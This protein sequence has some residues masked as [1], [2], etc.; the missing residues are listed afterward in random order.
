MSDLNALKTTIIAD[1]TVDAGEVDL[2]RNVMLADGTIDRAEAD[3]LF[4]INDAVSGNNNDPSW[5]V[6][7]SSAISSHVLEDAATPGIVSP[8]EAAY[9]KGRIHKDGNVDAAERALLQTLKDKAQQP[10]P[11]ELTFLFDMYLG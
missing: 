2:L 10:V 5:Q 4:E 1:G 7:F 8:E 3:T 9:L 11:P 6:F